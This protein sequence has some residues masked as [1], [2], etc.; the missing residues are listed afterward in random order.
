M[1]ISWKN[2]TK[3]FMFA[4]IPHYTA[5]Q[6]FRK[7]PHF[8]LC[9]PAAASQRRPGGM[10]VM[11]HNRFATHFFHRPSRRKNGAISAP[12]QAVYRYLLDG[13][14]VVP[15]W[16]CLFYS[17]SGSKVGQNFLAGGF[18]SGNF[19]HQSVPYRR[20]INRP[21]GMNI[22]IPGILDDSLRNQLVPR[23][24]L[25]EKLPRIRLSALQIL[26]DIIQK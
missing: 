2:L 15:V 18:Q 5:M 6:L 11:C 10:I 19:V 9:H 4:L 24:D 17:K 20:N 13:F 22:E 8:R 3:F 23:I 1:S 7:H 12:F 16:N 26:A 14:S 21:V 25:I